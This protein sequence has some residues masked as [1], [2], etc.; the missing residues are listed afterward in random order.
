MI[1][2]SGA[3]LMMNSGTYAG[4]R[5]TPQT[6]AY[7]GGV[8]QPFLED[9]LEIVAS[10]QPASGLTVDRLPEGKRNRETMEGYTM[11]ELKSAETGGVPD[12]IYIDGGTFEVESVRR[13]D[14]LGNY[15]EVVLTRV[16]AT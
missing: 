9:T 2:L 14:K 13:W 16:P 10:F 8:L 15:W 12:L 4:T 6:P 7:V 5:R 3:V 11:V 1:D